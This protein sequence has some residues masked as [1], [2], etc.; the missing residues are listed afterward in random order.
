MAFRSGSG[1]KVD[2]AGQVRKVEERRSWRG[3]R[4]RRTVPQPGPVGASASAARRQ[5]A[6]VCRL[7]S[8]RERA[9]TEQ[10]GGNDMRLVRAPSL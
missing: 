1:G 4:Q 5:Q 8:Q 10:R 3:G 6:S 7:V 9:Q 2:P